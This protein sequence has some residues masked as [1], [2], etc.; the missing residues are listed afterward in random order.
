[1]RWSMSQLVPDR[2]FGFISDQDGR[3]YFFHRGAVASARPRATPNSED[4]LARSATW[5]KPDNITIRV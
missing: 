2:G 3:E 1:M 5:L 4:S